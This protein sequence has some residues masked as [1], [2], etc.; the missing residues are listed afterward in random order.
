M[1]HFMTLDPRPFEAIKQGRKTIELRLNDEKRQTVRVGDTILFT[2]A[3]REDEG[4]SVRVVARHEFADFETLYKNLPLEKCGYTREELSTASPRDM[5]AYYSPE[6]QKQYGVLGIEI[7][8]ISP[9][10]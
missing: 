7:E 2:R 3:D 5:E 9:E 10:G 1:T 8:L 6:R 4:L